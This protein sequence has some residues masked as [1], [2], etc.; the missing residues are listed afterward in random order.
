MLIGKYFKKIK[1]DFRSH[2]FS[3]ICFN[4][5]LCEKNH[6]FFAIKG[7]EINGNNY[8]K[9]AISKGAKTIVYNKKFQG[10]KNGILYL[11]FNN[12]RKILAETSYKIFCPKIKNLIAVTGT[13]GKSSICNFYYQILNLNKKKVAS[14]GTLGLKTVFGN[15]PMLNTTVD[16]LQLSKH[17]M[18]ISEKKI[19]NVILEASSHG[20]K[21][22]RLD[23]LR[24]KKG[25]FT[26][27]SHDHLDYHKSF[28]DYLK[29]KLYLFDKLLSKKGI[30]ITDKDIPEYQKLLS[31]SKKKNFKLKKISNHTGDIEILNHKYIGEKQFLK[32]KYKN[33]KFSFYLNLIGKIQIKNLFMAILAAEDKNLKFKQIVK[34]LNKIQPVSGRLEKIGRLKNNALCLLDYAHSPDALKVCL[35][36]LK[37]QFNGKKISL[38]I[39]CGGNRDKSKRQIIGKIANKY[40]SKIYLTDDNPRN[41]NPKN[42]RKEIKKKIDKNKLFEIP[43]RKK[44]IEFAINNLSSNDILIVSGK[45]HENTQDLGKKK[46]FFS[47]KQVITNSIKIRNKSLSN[48]LKVNILKECVDTRKIP[49]LTKLNRASINSKDIKQNDIF[50]AIRGKKNDGNNFISESIRSGASI[51]VTDRPRIVTNNKKNII[52]VKNTLDFLTKISLKIRDNF[53]GKTIGITGSCGKTSVKEL[54]SSSLNKI[55]KVSSSPK[56]FNNKYGV[57]LSLF[58]LKLNNNYGV[59][60]IGMDKKGEIDFLS[61]LVKPDIGIITNVSYAHA[62]NFKNIFQIAKAKSEIINNIKSDG[63]IVLNA[64]DRFFSFHKKIATKRKLNIVTFGI[65]SGSNIKFLKIEKFGNYFKIKVKIFSESKVFKIRY[66]YMNYIKNILST[67]AVLSILRKTCSLN[68][69]F[70]EDFSIPVGRGNISKIKYKNKKF[71]LI[72]ESYNSNPLSLSSAISN[73]SNSSIEHKK[74]HFLMGDML[75]LGRHSRKLHR[76][77]SSS[78]NSSKINKIHIYGKD[79]IETFKAIKNNRKG[80]ILQN[81]SD[82]FD[83]IVRDLNNNDYLMIKGSNSTGLNKIVETLRGKI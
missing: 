1:P 75:E 46:I 60:E 63:Y 23:G 32:I 42:I 16:P 76:D 67:L 15:L 28:D 11:S 8:I 6:I 38:V 49:R 80:R 48:N 50:F 57:P 9:H 7:N 82:I 62:K 66:K 14:L 26:N 18:N 41:E 13:N 64:D 35:E 77:I 56:S 21:Q 17:L 25:I 12:V 69:N 55:G 31:I 40:C 65:S 19:N 36:S 45:G 59:F 43:N 33:V 44:A 81:T 20:L 4:S 72:D 51:I 24:F 74:K 52:K 3:G 22:H 78:L 79:V 37:D 54:V 5:K 73:F 30:V 61:S 27:L 83:L 70:F 68:I 39:G 2:Y 34:V 47:D 10:F 71:F 53:P 58:N 29:S